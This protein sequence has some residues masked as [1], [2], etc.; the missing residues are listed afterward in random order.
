MT[1]V[2]KKILLASLAL[3]AVLYGA[4]ESALYADSVPYAVDILN[5]RLID[6]GHL[7]WR[8][9]GMAIASASGHAMS[10]SY[11]LW[12]LQYL[13]LLSALGAVG[14]LYLAGRRLFPPDISMLVAVAAGLTNGFWTHAFS[15][16]SY[17][18]S[19][20][21]LV[22]ALYCVLRDS[23]ADGPTA[24]D[25]FLAGVCGGLAACSWT[26][27]AISGPALWVLVIHA[28]GRTRSTQA[29]LRRTALL[30]AGYALSFLLPLF[31]LYA[32][33]DSIGEAAYVTPGPTGLKFLSWLHS[34]D[35]GIAAGADLS[36]LLR[37]VA[38]WAQSMVSIGDLGQRLRLWSYREA[39]F[40]ATGGFATLVLFYLGVALATLTL[41]RSF[42]F[43]DASRRTVILAALV[44]CA[45]NFAF[46]FLWEGADLERYLPSLP[47]QALAFG[48]VVERWRT[49]WRRVAL[50]ASAFVVTAAVGLTWI[51]HFRAVLRAD[52]QRQTWNRALAAQFTAS[53]LVIVMGN[54]KFYVGEPH[55][56]NFPMVE[57]VSQDIR[58][59]ADGWR[60]AI[61][62]AIATTRQRG[63]RVL[64][65]DSVL[66]RDHAPR[67][68]WSFSQYPSP[69]P[70]EIADYFLPLKSDQLIV[71]IF[72]EKL[73]LGHSE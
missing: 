52:S 46:G 67:D 14:I 24:R 19:V 43:L 8:P 62:E 22:L 65:A 72:G 18:L 28:G 54:G 50:P 13:S 31:V 69:S 59:F 10:L 11:I 25:S 30:S 33:P 17:T 60:S 5:G 12:V 21:F 47:F 63:G 34:A 35:H 37:F 27:A 2:D 73:W 36:H 26:V 3:L 32:I 15:G 20:L 68:G 64:L 9:L 23:G 7:L 39:P 29:A 38:G 71:T 6:P 61:A 56:P 55:N 42:R 66:R 49:S 58:D 1:R 70:E 45:C 40:P 44:A 16:Y 41:L 4:T 57:N 51:T 48:L 53:D